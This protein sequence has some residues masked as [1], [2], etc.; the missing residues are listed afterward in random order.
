MAQRLRP[1]PK[2]QAAVADD[3][4]SY[5][6]LCELEHVSRRT[7]DGLRAKGLGPRFYLVGRQLRCTRGEHARWREKLMARGVGL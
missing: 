6:D 7:M 4:L 1:K 3:S 2:P 5:D